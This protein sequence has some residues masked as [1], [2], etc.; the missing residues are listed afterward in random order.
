MEKPKNQN[1]KQV[2]VIPVNKQEK[3]ESFATDGYREGNSYYCSCYHKMRKIG[4]CWDCEARDRLQ[5]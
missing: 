2:K 3:P 5:D 1:V 4:S